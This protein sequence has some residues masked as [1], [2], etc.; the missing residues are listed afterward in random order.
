MK[1]QQLDHWLQARKNESCEPPKVFV[2][3]CADLSHYS[4]A[5]EYKHKLEPILVK[6]QLA[7]FNSLES[8][9][10]ELRKLGLSS[11]YLRLHNAYDEFGHHGDVI[12]Q[13]IELYLVS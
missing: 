10:D 11:A 2:V 7:Y 1:K 5:V 4:L 12:Y 3:S 13:D 6:D 9:K 8:V